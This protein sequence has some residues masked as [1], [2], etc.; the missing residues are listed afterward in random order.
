MYLE[1]LTIK[2]ERHNKP[3]SR[4]PSQLNEYFF[5]LK[6]K[7]A[8]NPLFPM[9]FCTYFAKKYDFALL[10]GFTSFYMCDVII[11]YQSVCRVWMRGV[12][13]EIKKV[14]KMR[15]WKMFDKSDSSRKGGSLFN[16]LTLR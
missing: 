5:S 2:A 14:L 1:N 11:S 3:Q 4:W 8:L 16:Y 12:A 15:N 13:R 7:N 6:R 9:T 10:L